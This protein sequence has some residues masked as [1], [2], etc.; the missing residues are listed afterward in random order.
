MNHKK[1]LCWKDKIKTYDLTEGTPCRKVEFKYA[2][3]AHDSGADQILKN[4]VYGYTFTW[5]EYNFAIDKSG[6]YTIELDEYSTSPLIINV[7]DNKTNL[8]GYLILTVE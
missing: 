5:G 1:D 3:S 8:Y 7:D 4:N 6:T 2:L